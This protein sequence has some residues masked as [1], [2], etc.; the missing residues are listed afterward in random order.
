[1][2]PLPP[3]HFLSVGRPDLT[4]GQPFGMTDTSTLAAHDFDVDTRTGFLPPE[5]PLTRLPIDWEPWEAIL[6]DA[7]QRKLQ[8]GDR[9]NLSDEDIY[10]SASWR[11]RVSSVCPFFGNKI[12]IVLV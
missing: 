4:V 6:D 3:N 8:L 2:A 7:L 10:S 12:M 9:I 5:P 11:A 1:M